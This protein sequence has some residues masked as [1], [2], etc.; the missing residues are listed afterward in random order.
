M[1]GFDAGRLAGRIGR[2]LARAVRRASPGC[3][4]LRC[5]LCIWLSGRLSGCDVDD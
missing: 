2:I 5:M 4:Y 1:T 3:G